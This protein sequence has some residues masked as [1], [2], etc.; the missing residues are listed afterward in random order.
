MIRNVQII[1]KV[2]RSSRVLSS[3][4]RRLS[5]KAPGIGRVA[6]IGFGGLM[7]HGVA[8]MTAAAGYDV[9]G[10]ETQQDALDIGM[11]RIEGSL[12]KVA[13]RKIKKGT[14]DEAGAAEEV[15]TVLDR[16]KVTTDMKDIADVDLVVE[17]IVENMDIKLKFYKELGNIVQPN[18]IFAS[19]T[20]SLQITAMAEAS[21]RG[22][23]FVG[24]HFFNPVQLMKLVEVIR[25]DYTADDT[26]DRMLT[27]GQ[28]IGKTTASCVDT[29]GFI[30]NRL[31]VPYLAQALSMVDRGEATIE[32]IDVSMQLGAGHPMGPIHLSDYIGLDTMHSI[33]VGWQKDYPN[34]SAFIMPKV[35]EEKV[36][37]GHLGRK[38]GQ[39]FYKW[40]GDKKLD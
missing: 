17:A 33:I 15:Q 35:L 25:T 11:K 2:F 38:T 20:S 21:G 18:A 8:Q 1:P 29:P 5:S 36:K 7:G 40:E 39:G 32:D 6:V 14:L 12:S 28:S 19:N 37:A 24:L 34:E 13:A 22:Q 30:V 31:L 4:S 26:F 9:V 3:A 16:I 10:V 23:N 27:F